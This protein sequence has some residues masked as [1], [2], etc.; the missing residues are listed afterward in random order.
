MTTSPRV[1]NP[2]DEAIRTAVR[3][4]LDEHLAPVLAELR[5]ARTALPAEAGVIAQQPRGERFVSV[6]ELCDRLGVNRTTIARRE[7]AGK[8]PRRREFPDGRL[9]WTASEIE[10]WFKRATEPQDDGERRAGLLGRLHN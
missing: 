8:L 5:S 4:A 10:A 9:G 3:D 1:S 7:R 2:L 6:T